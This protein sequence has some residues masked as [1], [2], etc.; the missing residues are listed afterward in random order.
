M[1]TKRA[2]RRHVAL[3]P[4]QRLVLDVLKHSSVPLSAYAILEKLRGRGI[5]APVLIYR[6]LERLVALGMVHRLESLAAFVSCSCAHTTDREPTVFAIC[7]EC[8]R[9]R[10]FG[11]EDISERLAG[12][13]DREGFSISGHCI[14]LHGKCAEC[15]RS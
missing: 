4:N 13:A 6:A 14:E 2:P 15:A 8:G 10:E 3:T 7:N 12:W 1:Q 5:K 11:G 9:V